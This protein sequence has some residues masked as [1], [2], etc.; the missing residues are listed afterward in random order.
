MKSITIACRKGGTGKTATVSAL[1]AGLHRKGS[2]VL[3]VDLDSQAN[4]TFSVKA[5]EKNNSLEVMSGQVEALEAIQHCDY[6]DI[7]PGSGRLSA[8]DV[9]LDDTGKEYRLKEALEP[10]KKKYDYVIIDTPAALG[11]LTINALTAANSVV[12]PVQAD[13][14]SLQGLGQLFKTVERVKKYCNKGL[15]VDG[16]LITRYNGRAVL[17]RD[18]ADG[19]GRAA[20]NMNTK[21]FDTKIRECVAVKEAQMLQKSIF[22]YAPNSNAAKDYS[23]FI[24]E[25]IK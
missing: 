17:S 10:L 2:R 22:D 7:I 1:A 18:M 21:L 4:L 11:T 16:I 6:C 5:S 24:G 23:A 12:I 14:Y 19:I 13:V 15:S 9:V 20:K 8:A 3:V 25:L